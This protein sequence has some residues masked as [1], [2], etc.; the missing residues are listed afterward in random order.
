MPTHILAMAAVNNLPCSPQDRVF[1]GEGLFETIR[2]DNGR[3]C[4]PRQ[5]WQ[6]LQQ[7]ALALN[8]P[9]EVSLAAWLEHLLAAIKASGVQ[10]GGI[11]VLLTSGHAPRGLA[12]QSTVSYLTF[13]AFSGSSPGAPLSL[14]TA[15]WLRD[16]HNPVY[17]LKSI[18]YLESIIARRQALA[19]GADDVLFFNLTNHATETTIANLFLINDGQLVTPALT[20]GILPGIIRSRLIRLCTDAGV[21]C[22]ETDVD[23]AAIFNADAV[24]V[25]NALQRIRLVKSLDGIPLACTHKLIARLQEL[26]IHDNKA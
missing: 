14:V 2:V 18:N 6:R 5:H 20:S 4:Y 7:S 1:L 19:A 11:K 24:M 9:F 23:S 16:A 8:I 13:N 10:D 26:L 22:L 25:T 21:P 17:R 15:S 12:E 3:C